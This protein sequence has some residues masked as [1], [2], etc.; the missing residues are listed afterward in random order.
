MGMFELLFSKHRHLRR[1]SYKLKRL[2]MREWI[3]KDSK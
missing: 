2:S 3:E 1:V